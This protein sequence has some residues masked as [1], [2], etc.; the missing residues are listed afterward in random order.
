MCLQDI[1]NDYV[2]KKLEHLR[3]QPGAKTLFE[4]PEEGPASVEMAA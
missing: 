4:K 1:L 2:L 3:K